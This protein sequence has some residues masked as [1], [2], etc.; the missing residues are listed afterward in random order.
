M[1]RNR[2]FS[3]WYDED[4]VVPVRNITE[5][6]IFA[7]PLFITIRTRIRPDHQHHTLFS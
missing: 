7:M 5:L 3:H 1:T 2:Y 6:V 4:I